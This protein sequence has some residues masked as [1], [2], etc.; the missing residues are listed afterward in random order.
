MTSV[1]RYTSRAEGFRTAEEIEALRPI[2]EPKPRAPRKAGNPALRQVTNGIVCFCG[3]RFGESQALEFMLH[4]RAEVGEVL[5]WRER[6]LRQDRERYAA[7]YA[8]PE[9]RQ[10]QRE[11]DR[12]YRERIAAAEGRELLVAPADRTHCPRGH[13]YTP[14]NTYRSRRG[15]GR[16]CR[17]C[18]REWQQA[19]R[20]Q[21]AAAEGRLLLPPPGDR[22]HCPQGHE[23]TPENTYIQPSGSRYC[24]KCHAETM[25][26]ARARKKAEREAQ[27]SQ[28]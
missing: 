27:A 23:Y 22:T 20:V 10:L 4:L 14:E 5:E 26:A 18:D 6:K 16:V 1:P 15:K 3:E 17:T 2:A 19:A 28:P 8:D 21:E 9:F 25:R 24:R 12:D 13:E 7:R 11:R